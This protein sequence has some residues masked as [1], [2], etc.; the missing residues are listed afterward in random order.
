MS[1]KIFSLKNI[2][3]CK[4][5]NFL[6]KN[7]HLKSKE[8][9]WVIPFVKGSPSNIVANVLVYDILSN[10]LELQLRYSLGKG[11]NVLLP[12]AIG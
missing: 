7:N 1:D 2:D 8:M 12:A 10:E 3:N 11:M 4:V 5:E 9:I 6:N